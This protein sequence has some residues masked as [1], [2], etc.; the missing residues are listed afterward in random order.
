VTDTIRALFISVA[1]YTGGIG[2]AH[3]SFSTC[4]VIIN[5]TFNTCF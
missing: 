5:N 4:T 1:F 2:I 3:R